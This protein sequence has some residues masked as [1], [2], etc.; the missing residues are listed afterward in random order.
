AT[1]TGVF[2]SPAPATPQNYAIPVQ[3]TVTAED[4]S[5]QAYTVTVTQAP[6]EP[7]IATALWARTVTAG[8]DMS[9]FP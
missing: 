2:I 7:G 5:S 9:V 6:P 4:G 8:S 1:H 3:F